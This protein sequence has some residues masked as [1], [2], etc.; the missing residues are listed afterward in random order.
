M[1]ARYMEKRG[2]HDYSRFQ[3]VAYRGGGFGG[4]TPPPPKF[5][6]FDKAETNSQFRGKYM[7]NCLVFLFH[8]PN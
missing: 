4:F 2:S 7:R 1:E 3:A 5:R 6:S 8:H